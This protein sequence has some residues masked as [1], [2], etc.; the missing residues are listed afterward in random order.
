MEIKHKNRLTIA[1]AMFAALG[2]SSVHAIQQVEYAD[3]KPV[4]PNPVIVVTGKG[5][6]Y[7]EASTNKLTFG[8]E[9]KGRCTWANR[10]S[11]VAYSLNK[12]NYQPQHSGD[13]LA[14]KLF[15]D[16]TAGYKNK[17]RTW[18]SSMKPISIKWTPNKAT[19]DAAVKSCN[20]KRS[21][22]I[23]SGN[24]PKG[25]FQGSPLNNQVASQ[26]SFECS[27][28]VSLTPNQ[29]KKFNNPRPIDVQCEKLTPAMPLLKAN[30]IPKFEL[31]T[32]NLSM[33][34]TNYKG[35]CPADLKVNALIKTNSAGGSFKYRF[36]EDGT[37][38]T[39]WINRVFNKNKTS[40]N[41][42]HHVKAEAPK[43]L[44]QQP[45]GFQMQGQGNAQLN[46]QLQQAPTRK[47]GIQVKT[48][49]Q[50]ISDI[51]EHSVT[52]ITPKITQFG[53]DKS[54]VRA[55]LRPLGK[56]DLTSRVG[57]TIG[58]TS[59][60]WGGMLMLSANEALSN[61]ARGCRFRFKYDV[62]NLGKADSGPA[63]HKLRKGGTVIHTK[64]G[65]T[66]K[67]NQSKNVSGHITLPHGNYSL[68]ASIDDAKSVAELK[69]NNNKF[70]V[71]VK[72]DQSCGGSS[73][74]QI[75]G[76]SSSSSSSRPQM[77]ARTIPSIQ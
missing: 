55:T 72:V 38:V 24:A 61:N 7:T 40:T 28:L 17:K 53:G 58:S 1:A 54:P 15:V 22:L 9:A 32:V 67:K 33:P 23:N 52:C 57:I 8:G 60:A 6:S 71:T 65:F 16:T 13:F 12:P 48:G 27:T 4:G 47:V 73:R 43:V 56:P 25:S 36:L 42:I 31:K 63:T 59:S 18:S 64:H 30:L 62:V 10:Y 66:V 29:E 45:K 21:S 50:Q 76:S 37:P 51:H 49:E 39:G 11:Y 26:F 14:K 77:P 34:K 69:E 35:L 46:P 2:T 41:V 74:P 68:S 70:N 20:D 5:S 75:P 19:R 44:P 3:M